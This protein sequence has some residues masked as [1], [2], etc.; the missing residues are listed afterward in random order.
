MSLTTLPFFLPQN[1]T[2]KQQQ[3]LHLHERC[4]HANWEQI[5]AWIHAGS[6][7]SGKSLA[8]EPDP[9]CAACQFGKAHKHSH[10]ANTGHISTN[11]SAPGKCIS[12]DGLE[13]GCPGRIMTTHGLPSSRRYKYV[14]FWLDHFS[15][16][17]YVTMHKTKKA[18]ELLRSK[19]EFE[20]YAACFGINI[21]NI[22]ADNGVYMAKIIQETCKK[23]QQNLSF[24]AVGAHW[25]IGIAERFIGSIVQHSRTL[26]LHAMAKWPTMIPEDMWPFAICHMV[27]FHNT[28]LRRGKSATPYQLFIGQDAPWSLLDFRVPRVCAS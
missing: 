23:K 9:V 24:C 22:R 21:K 16:F 2:P 4:A 17:V 12:S 7:P 5:N 25:Q 15:Q 1:L 19:S 10:K 18:E 6:L 11:H 28:S 3:K 8:S 26:L 20:E 27:S 13:A 14:S